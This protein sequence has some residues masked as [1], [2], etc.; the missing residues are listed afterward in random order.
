MLLGNNGGFYSSDHVAGR[1]ATSVLTLAILV[2]I[3]GRGSST[4]NW[5]RQSG[6]TS[7]PSRLKELLIGIV[8]LLVL[9]GYSGFH[10]SGLSQS[11]GRGLISPVVIL[12]AYGIAAIRLS[13][14]L[15]VRGQLVLRFGVSLGFLIG[16]V[17]GANVAEQFSWSSRQAEAGNLSI[18][19]LLL[20]GA[21]AFGTYQHIHSI[22]LGIVASIWSAMMG[23][24]IACLIGLVTTLFLVPYLNRIAGTNYLHGFHHHSFNFSN[25]LRIMTSYLLEAPIQA[26][27]LGAAGGLLSYTFTRFCSVNRSA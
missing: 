26:V 5:L 25:T 27:V 9:T 12:I 24:I 17:Q 3:I 10:Y 21:V 22:R 8:V 15:V 11:S 7:D 4:A 2:F 16:V 18:I 19:V 14:L 20:F 6:Q 1:L 23:T 13:P